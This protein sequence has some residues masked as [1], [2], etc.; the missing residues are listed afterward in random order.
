MVFAALVL[1]GTAA[2]LV[3]LTLPLGGGG[4]FGRAW[5][6]VVRTAANT[7]VYALGAG[8]V[9]VLMGL[10]VA[11]C[12]GHSTRFRTAGA[13]L[14]LTLF[15]LPPAL[16]A[17]GVVHLAAL[18]PAWADCVLRSRLTVCLAL[19][20]RFFPVAA[21][22]C[23]HSWG[24]MPAS[25]ALAGGLHGVPVGTYLAR[26]ALPF[27]APTLAT[28]FLLVAVLATAEVG[29]VLLLHPPGEASFPL[30]VFTVMANAPESLVASLCLL[31][32]AAGGGVLAALG[33]LTGRR[34]V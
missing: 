28:G 9:A 18:A 33:A 4:A 26:V 10:L 20:L 19:G 7:A 16:S 12:V 13:G 29:T 21:V 3:G 23:L 31:Y 8:G 6:E 14:A 1:T 30:A 22:L 24:A 15:A 5:G 17:L 32:V 27:L 2:P 25:W 11:G 34:G